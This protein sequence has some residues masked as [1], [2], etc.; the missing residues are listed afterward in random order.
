MTRQG[1]GA[2]RLVLRLCS[3]LYILPFG[4]LPHALPFNLRTLVT[5]ATGFIGSILVRRLVEEGETLRIFRRSSSSLDL[6][7]EATSEVEHVIGDLTDPVAVHDA[8]AD[9]DRIYHVAARIAFGRTGDPDRLHAV[10]VQGTSNLIDAALEEDIDRFL[11]T[12]SVAALGPPEREGEVADESSRWRETPATTEYARSKHAAELEVFRGQA[13]GLEVVIANPAL[14]FGPEDPGNATMQIVSRIRE[15]RMPG[16]P[17]GG[18]NVVDVLDAAAGLQAVMEEGRPGERYYLGSEALT[19]ARVFEILADAFE[20]EPPTWQLPPSLLRAAG[21]I[22]DG[23]GTV[24]PVRPP[25]SREI[26]ESALTFHR[27][28]NEKAH[29]ELGLE[30]RP[31]EETAERLAAHSPRKIYDEASSMASG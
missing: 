17:P 10:N 9:V 7:G 12:S 28:S 27:Y 22:A 18:T 31:F 21:W 25:L 11:H 26:V 14:V 6:L 16:V 15:E 8:V 2:V 30:F 24:L 19:W 29:R 1:A 13:E 20:V 4:D 23:V 3:Q 5:G